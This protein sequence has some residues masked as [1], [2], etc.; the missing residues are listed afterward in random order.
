MGCCRGCLAVEYGRT[1][2]ISMFACGCALVSPMV[3][4]ADEPQIQEVWVISSMYSAVPSPHV[5]PAH[6]G[7][8]LA[9]LARW[10][11]DG[12]MP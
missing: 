6:H 10:A 5:H 12:C 3:L 1:Y 11:P 9:L 8:R 7:S 4:T 2:L